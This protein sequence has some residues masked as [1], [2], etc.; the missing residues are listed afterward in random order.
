MIKIILIGLLI[1]LAGL[2]TAFALID[3]Y[4]IGE[5]EEDS[6]TFVFIAE[7]NLQSEQLCNKKN[8]QYV[9]YDVL[10]KEAV[11][12]TKSPQKYYRYSI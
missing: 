5:N 9:T 8:M 11:C 7:Q 3:T 4:V 10:T 2:L 6:V 12:F 1:I